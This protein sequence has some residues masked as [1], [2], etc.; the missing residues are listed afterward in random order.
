MKSA[1]MVNDPIQT[2]PNVAAIGI[3]FLRML[4]MEDSLCPCKV[5]SYSLSYLATSLGDDPETSIQVLEK[6][7]QVNKTKAM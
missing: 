6:I 7:A 1:R 2:P 5:K 4:N 3:Y